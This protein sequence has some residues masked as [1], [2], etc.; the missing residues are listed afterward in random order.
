[1]EKYNLLFTELYPLDFDARMTH[2][3]RALVIYPLAAIIGF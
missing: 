3:R 2:R 1:M